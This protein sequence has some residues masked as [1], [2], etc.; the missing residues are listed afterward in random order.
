MLIRHQRAIAAF[1]G[2]IILA[3]ALFYGS[4]DLENIQKIIFSAIGLIIALVA[5]WYSYRR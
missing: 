5:I 2:G 1:I 4:I 3:S